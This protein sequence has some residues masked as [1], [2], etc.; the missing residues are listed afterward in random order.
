MLPG[1]FLQ[2]FKRDLVFLCQFR[3]FLRIARGVS[4]SNVD[5][6]D[7]FFTDADGYGIEVNTAFTFDIGWGAAGYGWQRRLLS[8]AFMA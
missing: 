1:C 3:L 5:G 8:A 7:N 6:A 2:Y 4:V